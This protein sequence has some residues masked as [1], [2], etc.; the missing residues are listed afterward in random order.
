MRCEQ[1][2]WVNVI[3]CPYQVTEGFSLDR[4][5]ECKKYEATI[6]RTTSFRCR[7][8]KTPSEKRDFEAAVLAYKL[9]LPDTVE[10]IEDKAGV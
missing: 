1:M 6:R 3:R 5:W 10:V 7:A 4:C 9:G 8:Q 2:A